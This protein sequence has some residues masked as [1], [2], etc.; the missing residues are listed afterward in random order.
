MDFLKTRSFPS[1]Y[2]EYAPKLIEFF[3]LWIDWMNE[4]DNMAYVIDHLS[5]ESDIDESIERY[6]SSIKNKIL[7]DYP[8]EISSDLKLLLKNIFYLYNSKASIKSYDF[9]FRCLYDSPATILYP[10][11]YI[12]RASDGRWNI[13]KY[14]STM[15]MGNISSK[16]SPDELSKYINYSIRGTK[17]NASAFISGSTVYSFRNED[18]SFETRYCVTLDSVIGVFEDGESLIVH[19]VETDEEI[20]D[21]FVVHRFEE[22]QGY[23]MSTKGFLDSNMIIQDGYYYQDFSYIIRSKVS[24]NKWQ[25]LKRLQ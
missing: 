16:D 14:M 18:L 7:S 21:I 22:G 15:Y 13:P 17:T 25:K 6:K 12:L 11:D 19:N 4:S 10:K 5:S 3:G 20:K 8:E 24:I 2:Q 23:W 1:F 9:L